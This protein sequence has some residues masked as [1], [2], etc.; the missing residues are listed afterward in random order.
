VHNL[1]LRLI[2]LQ[3]LGKAGMYRNNSLNCGMDK[4]VVPRY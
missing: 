1:I 3:D 4:S 2:M